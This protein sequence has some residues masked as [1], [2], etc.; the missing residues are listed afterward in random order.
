M[1]DLLKKIFN[2]LLVCDG[3]TFDFYLSEITMLS[4]FYGIDYWSADWKM[5]KLVR[6]IIPI[7]IIF[8]LSVV[9][10]AYFLIHSRHD[11]DLILTVSMWGLQGSLMLGK[12]VMVF[13]HRKKICDLIKEV[14]KDF[15]NIDEGEWLKKK[16]LVDGSRVMRHLIR[17]VFFM[18]LS[19]IVIYVTAPVYAMIVRSQF[20]SP[21]KFP[22]PGS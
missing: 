20:E 22:L 11:L 12:F 3:E 16:T 15:W 5:G 21:L 1:F 13:V 18:Y 9:F 2:S 14:R 17:L 10:E 8:L 19:C 7:F 4:R 6:S